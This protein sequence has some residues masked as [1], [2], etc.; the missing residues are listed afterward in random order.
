[1]FSKCIAVAAMV[2]LPVLA[3]AQAPAYPPSS[4]ADTAA[5]APKPT[6]SA[7]PSIDFSGILFGNYQYRGDEGPQKSQNRFDVER[8]YLT[9]RMSAG[10]RTNIRITTDLFQQTTSGN[11]AYYRGW[12][13]RAKYAYLQYNYLDSPDWKAHARVGLLQTVFIEHDEQFWPRWI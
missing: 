1:M 6:A 11:D 3:S 7:A 8:A 9:F 13:V 5:P 4:A 10:K 2:S 12:I